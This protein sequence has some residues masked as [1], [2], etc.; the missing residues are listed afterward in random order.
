LAGQELH[1]DLFYEKRLKISMHQS[2]DANESCEGKTYKTKDRIPVKVG[3]SSIYDDYLLAD[4]PSYVAGSF[5]LYDVGRM[6][7]N[8]CH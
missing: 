5:T 2:H 3:E 6:L 8:L 1:K 7:L 4:K